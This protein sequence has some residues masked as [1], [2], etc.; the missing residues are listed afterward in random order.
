LDCEIREFFEIRERFY[1]KKYWL[2]FSLLITLQ[3]WNYLNIPKRAVTGDQRMTRAIRLVIAI[4][5]WTT[6][7]K[8]PWGKQDQLWNQPSMRTTIQRLQR[9]ETTRRRRRSAS[10]WSYCTTWS[11]RRKIDVTYLPLNAN[12]V[13]HELDS[14]T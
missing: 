9:R 14:L 1:P 10:S 4:T 7:I 11:L 3:T 8:D 2:N 13:Y 6:R 12:Y 5:D